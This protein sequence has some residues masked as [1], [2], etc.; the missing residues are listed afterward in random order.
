MV[1][2]SWASSMPRI[3]EIMPYYRLAD[4][5]TVFQEMDQWLR[6]RL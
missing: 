5:K 1:A 6:R 4:A 3:E 2:V